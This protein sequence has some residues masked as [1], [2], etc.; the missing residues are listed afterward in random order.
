MS[1]KNNAILA[2]IVEA[3]TLTLGANI[4]DAMVNDV[5]VDSGFASDAMDGSGKA[6]AGVIV[7]SDMRVLCDT[8]GN[9]KL[10]KSGASAIAAL[11]RLVNGNG[12]AF[13]YVKQVKSGGVGDPIKT[14][15]SKY[16]S[17]K[18]E[19]LAAQKQEN[20]LVAK[21]AS[22]EALD[23]DTAT[24]GSPELV[25]YTDLQARKTAVTAWKTATATR[26]TNLETALTAA[27]IDLITLLPTTP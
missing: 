1:V 18:T 21:I 12:I 8:S 10:Y 17:C 3:N 20:D 23:W 13:Q 2:A 5:T 6:I 25:E 15:V 4:V 19:L 22:A 26:K 24:A 16:K 7:G 27:N 9:V 11:R 14:L